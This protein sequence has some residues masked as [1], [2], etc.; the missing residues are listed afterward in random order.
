M[1]NGNWNHGMGTGSWWWIPMMI[2][3][4]AFW[5]GVIWIGVT[6]VKRSHAPHVHGLGTPPMATPARPAAEEVLADRLA[7][8][9]IEPDEYRQR[10]EALRTPPTT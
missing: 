4:V 3:M 9:E 2:M 1:R 6:L 10:I 7:R 5:G 8:G